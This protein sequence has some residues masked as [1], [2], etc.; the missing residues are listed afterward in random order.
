AHVEDIV[1]VLHAS[2]CAPDPGA[3]Y[4]VCDDDPAPPE[5]VIEHAARLIGVPVPP[6]EDHA[7]TEMTPM[8][9]SFYAESKRVR[10]E[11]IKRDL[12]IRLL[13]PTYREGLAALLAGG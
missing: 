13:Y 7:E 6:A 9:R 1:Q 3:I 5:D 11:R 8:A 12:G 10:N 2:M 4:N